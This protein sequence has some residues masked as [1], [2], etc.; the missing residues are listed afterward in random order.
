M[1]FAHETHRAVFETVREYLGELF[2]EAYYD[3]KTGH[4]YVQYGSTVLEISVDPYGP[5]DAAVM[6]MSY[7]VQGVELEQDL[8]LGLLE[9]NHTLPF[10][11]FSL[12]GNDIFFSHGV[13]GKTLERR[14]LLAAIAAVATISDDYDELIVRKYGGQTAIDRIQETGGRIRRKVSEPRLATVE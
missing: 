14:N 10:G 6:V 7:C 11:A 13:L 3:K 2:E 5:E 9:L 8:L 1:K 12:V 4:T